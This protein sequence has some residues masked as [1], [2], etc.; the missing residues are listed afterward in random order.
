MDTFPDRPRLILTARVYTYQWPTR[1]EVAAAL[2]WLT[3][4]ERLDCN[5]SRLDASFND[6]EM[7]HLLPPSGRSAISPSDK[8]C[9]ASQ[10]IGS[11]TDKL[12]ELQTWPDATVALQYQENG[13]VTLPELNPQKRSSGAIYR[14]S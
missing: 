12:P 10:T 8:I 11:Y 9:K 6:Y 14:H 5:V 2:A 1:H 3:R 13:H 7:Q 4:W